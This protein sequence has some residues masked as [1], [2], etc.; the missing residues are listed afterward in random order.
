MAYRQQAPK[1]QDMTK[2]Q[3][4]LAKN[5]YRKVY[6]LFGEER[7]LVLQFRDVLMKRIVAP[8]DTMNLN[9]HKEQAPEVSKVMDECLSMPFFAER[10]LVVLQDCGYFAAAGKDADG[11]AA[12]GKDARGAEAAVKDEGRAVT[13]GVDA[14][15][16][17]AAGEKAPKVGKGRKKKAAPGT[18]QEVL[19]A[20]LEQIPESTVL[21]FVETKVDKRNRL[22]KAVQKA[23]MTVEFQ[24]PDE[25]QLRLWINQTF[26]KHKIAIAK[27]STDLILERAG[28]NM[29]MLSAQLDKLVSCAGEGGTLSRKDVADLVTERLDT[30]V[31]K[32]MDAVGKRNRKEVVDRYDEL[33]R[34]KEKDQRILASVSR[35]FNCLFMAKHLSAENRNLKEM[36]EL[37]GL[38]FDFQVR[39]YVAQSKYFTEE[40][41]K[42]AIEDCAALD[43]ASK[44][45][46]SNA[47]FAIETLLLK[48]SR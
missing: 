44:T 27:E 5:I 18:P 21:L 42:S 4:E 39:N 15:G 45:G 19:A 31:Y 23:G 10:R 6:L 43:Q 17:A 40:Q 12:A 3:G 41:L 25:R 14:R 11:G 47:S 1:N 26:S 7:Y 20:F 24:L 32:L 9:F 33:V 16:A 46:R 30:K 13:A 29:S 37:M 36:Q 28:I 48:Y 22:Y 34:M 8:D 35:A 2:L 38:N